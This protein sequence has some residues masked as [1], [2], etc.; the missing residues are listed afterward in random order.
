[1][2][3]SRVESVLKHLRNFVFGFFRIPLL[4]YLYTQLRLRLLLFFKGMKTLDAHGSIQSTSEH[5]FKSL[6]I[7]TDR[8][9]KLFQS[10]LLVE[11]LSQ[12]KALIIGCRTEEEIFLF[13]GYGLHDVRAIDISSYSPL[14]ELGDMHQLPYED[15]SF[16]FVFCAYTISYSANPRQ[17]ASEMIRVLR[18]GG[19]VAMVMEYC[20]W[21]ER[22]EIED[23]L[24][25]YRLTPGE[26]LEC[27]DDMINL[28]DGHIDKVFMRYDAEMKRHHGI[29][30][31]IGLPSP[32]AAVFSIVKS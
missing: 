16:D 20:P 8:N 2:T 25:G 30:G 22:A 19:L 26:R 15:S 32:V 24:L 9:E 27:F 7:F 6:K 17:A 5:N 18:N 3:S 10:C 1:L 21:S 14:I 23:K 29:Q 28:F 4:R 12:Y 11:D 31:M 13:K